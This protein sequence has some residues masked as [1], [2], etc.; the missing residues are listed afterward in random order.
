[1]LPLFA[2]IL[3]VLILTCGLAI[4]VSLL[5]IRKIELQGAADAAA[6]AAEIQYERNTNFNA[7]ITAAKADASLNGFTDGASNTT[8]SVGLQPSY[9][10]YAGFA[11]AI[12]VRIVQQ[13]PTFFMG[14][15]NGGNV[16]LNAIAVALSPPCLYV[17]GAA[18]LV[19]YPL[20]I[21]S[22][23]LLRAFC[24]IYANTGISSDSSSNMQVIG[25][26][27]AGPAS[28]SSVAGSYNYAPR[29]NARAITDPL[30]SVAQPSVSTSS[31]DQT[32]YSKS[33]GTVT[34]N[35]GTYC[36]GMSLTNVTVTMN[37]GLYVI[38]GGAN[39][40]A[41]KVSG[42]GV[43]LFFTTGGGAGYGQFLITNNSYLT[44]SAPLDTSGGAV[45]TIL[46][47]GDRNWVHTANQDFQ[48]SQSTI[49]GDG[50][51][52]TTGTGLSFNACNISAGHYFSIV[53]DNVT[54]VGGGSGY[55][56]TSDYSHIATGNPYETLGGLVQ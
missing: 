6:R 18:G 17:T 1:M 24:P 49:Y 34:L 51:W 8:I 16:T 20:A 27:V 42:S 12:Q 3:P 56:I 48:C 52:Y 15:L 31:C 33:G 5:Q 30:A 21:S 46:V 53:S 38:T 54:M 19:T 41:A 7:A 36:K 29:Y 13:V 10:A 14:T 4:D 28:A 22:S 26:N 35:P 37:P 44:F 23:A 9:G 11:D 39:W 50:I 55:V 47:F 45:P 43:T 2:A 32:S 25:T 40:N